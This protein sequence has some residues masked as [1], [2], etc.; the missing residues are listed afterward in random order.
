MAK[1]GTLPAHT[2]DPATFDYK[3][4]GLVADHEYTVW[5]VQ[6][7]K[8][9]RAIVLRNPWGHFEPRGEG[10]GKDDGIF[11]LP[12]DRFMIELETASIGG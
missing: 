10:D 2:Y 11:A 3:D 6:G 7:A 5:G 12:F 1:Q 8:A 9:D 4:R